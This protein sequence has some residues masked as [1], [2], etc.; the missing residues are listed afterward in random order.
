MRMVSSTLGSA[1]HKVSQKDRPPPL[2]DDARIRRPKTIRGLPGRY[3]SQ[4]SCVSKAA[5][6]I[7]AA[8]QIAEDV[9][10]AVLVLLVIPERHALGSR[11]IGRDLLLVQDVDVA[12]P[13]P[14]QAAQSALQ[15]AQSD[16]GR[17]AG[18]RLCP[19]AVLVALHGKSSRSVSRTM[20]MAKQWYFRACSTKRFRSSGAHVGCIHNSETS[21]RK[22]LGQQVVERVE[23]VRRGRLIVLVVA[24]EA[25]KEIRGQHFGRQKMACAQR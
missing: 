1:V 8:M 11:L 19:G 10:R 13:L 21:A 3:G 23:G 22:A 20:A 17:R 6:F 14:L 18:R 9:E 4:P 16:G 24:D 5:Q 12:E 7:G 15:F 25:A 2:R